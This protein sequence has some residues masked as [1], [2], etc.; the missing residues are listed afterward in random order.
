[1][2]SVPSVFIILTPAHPALGLES[3]RLITSDSVCSP[4]M[5]SGLRSSTYS[6]WHCLMAV[7]LARA[8]PKLWLL[9]MKFMS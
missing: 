8:N 2:A 7:L 6:P 4:T 5:V 3:M 1:M 9:L